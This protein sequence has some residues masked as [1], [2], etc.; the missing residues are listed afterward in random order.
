MNTTVFLIEDDDHLKRAISALLRT[1]GYTVVPITKGLKSLE[2]CVQREP[3]CAVVDLAEPAAAA[4][5]VEELDAG[6][7]GMPIVL[8]T[9]DEAAEIVV[10]TIENQKCE[11]LRKPVCC[12]DLFAAIGRSIN[13]NKPAV[14]LER[15]EQKQ[16]QKLTG[17]QR[18]V[19][20]L[21]VAGHSTKRIAR[22]LGISERTVDA[23]RAEIMKKTGAKNVP[24]LVRAEL[25]SRCPK[26]TKSNS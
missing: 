12:Q 2:Q 23:H 14:T 8:L 24:R 9:R 5:V 7:C 1:N 21:V 6:R 13:R 26:S 10:Q 20:D 18:Q 16:E 17:R 11:F 22:E 3:S 4:D 25:C 19:M 15:E